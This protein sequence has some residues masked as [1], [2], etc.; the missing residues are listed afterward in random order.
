MLLLP[1]TA[2]LQAENAILESTA[3][4][5]SPGGPASGKARELQGPGVMCF[6]FK[7]WTI[8][9]WNV[10]SADLFIHVSKGAAPTSLEI[11]VI[12]TPWT[13]A[14]PPEASASWKFVPHQS[15]SEPQGWVSIKVDPKLVEEITAGK[16]HG[17]A[18]R[19]KSAIGIN[20]RESLAFRP[21]LIING[22]RP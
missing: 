17:L 3:D 13:E 1:G 20:T 19:V 8:F 16:G 4:A 9:K 6:S 15:V 14:A 22:G 2:C 18:V 5:S 11:A 21:Y 10:E 12:P 7:T